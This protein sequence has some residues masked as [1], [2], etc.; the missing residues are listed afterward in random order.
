MKD[1]K[2][3]VIPCAGLGRRMQPLS[4]F[5]PKEVFPIANFP[6]IHFSIVETTQAGIS[7]IIIILRKNKELIRDYT[8]WLRTQAEFSGVKFHYFYQSE[9]SGSGDALLI[10]RAILA[11]TPFAVLFPD[12]IFL[13]FSATSPLQQLLAVFRQKDQSI[14]AMEVAGAPAEILPYGNIQGIAMDESSS[15][16]HVERIIE[17]P[18]LEEITT[19]YATVGRYI[20]LPD[21]I[22]YFC[23]VQKECPGIEHH[24]T[25]ALNHYAREKTLLALRLKGIRRYDAG[26]PSGYIQ[27]L[28]HFSQNH[29]AIII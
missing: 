24:A 11:Q 6:L 28:F 2:V 7:E 12:N 29:T 16:L 10:A 13:P 5:V 20:L 23:R 22:E 1:V 27:T 17:K 19:P 4:L 18:T 8:E 14:I 3:A 26:N 9:P 21:V 25:I 15:L